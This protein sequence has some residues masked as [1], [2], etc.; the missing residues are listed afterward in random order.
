MGVVGG[1]AWRT[2]RSLT[3]TLDH[4]FS[5]HFKG[6]LALLNQQL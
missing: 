3:I 5:A 6:F 1:G 2:S 4:V